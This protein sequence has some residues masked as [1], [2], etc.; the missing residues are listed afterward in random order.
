[1]NGL[2][3]GLQPQILGILFEQPLSGDPF[4]P[5]FFPPFVVYKV[6]RAY[7]TVMLVFSSSKLPG[8]F[9]DFSIVDKM[10]MV[11][12]CGFVKGVNLC[13]LGLCCFFY[14]GHCRNGEV[15]SWPWFVVVIF[16]LRTSKFTFRLAR[17]TCVCTYL[18]P[19]Q[20]SNLTLCKNQ[21]GSEHVK[22]SAEKRSGCFTM[23]YN[24]ADLCREESRKRWEKSTNQVVTTMIRVC[25]R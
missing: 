9:E 16:G 23:H 22:I 25:G 12:Q 5:L 1:M 21:N 11:A 10:V 18:I 17:N 20:N 14:K 3:A 19:S 13:S 15:H 24:M 8:G 4:V 7:G 2:Q 6:L